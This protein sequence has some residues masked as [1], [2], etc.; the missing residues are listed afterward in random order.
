MTPINLMDFMAK[1]LQKLLA[2]CSAK[3]PSGIQPVTVYPGYVP[4][5]NNAQEKKSSVYVLVIEAEDKPGNTKSHATVEI[6][7]SIYDDEHTDG[8]RSLFNVMEHV[9]QDLLKY[10]FVNM[11]HR[12]DLEYAPIKTRIVENQ[13]FPQWQGTMTAAYTIDQPDE[14]GMNFDDF[15]ETKAYWDYKEYEKH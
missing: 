6:G 1:R 13:P 8:W 10:R 5:Q 15:Q 2:D 14:E 9:R 12:L 3:Q 11:Q 4:V 7:F